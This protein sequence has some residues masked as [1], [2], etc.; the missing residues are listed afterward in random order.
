MENKTIK[1]KE[2][3]QSKFTQLLSNKK[4][5][6][7]LMAVM[8][9]PFLIAIGIFGTIVYREAK[10]LMNM[11]SGNT[12]TRDENLISQM[13]YVLRE[14]ATDL[15]K[16]YFAELKHAIEDEPKEGEEPV[17]DLTIAELI[18]KNY[19]A[20]FYTWTNKQGQYDVGGMYYVFDGRYENNDNFKENVYLA[21]RDGFYKYI[22]NYIT[23]YGADKL[24]EVENVE[25]TSSQKAPWKF[26]LNEHVSYKQDSEG[27][28]YD[29]RED[30]EYDAYLVSC[31]WTY[32]EE[33]S[34]N[35]NQF[36]KTINLLVIKNDG[37]FS[38]IEAS[39]S[40]INERVKAET[41]DAESD[42]E[43]EDSNQ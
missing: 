13:N 17:S 4:T 8:M 37:R 5:R 42:E 2:K 12:E 38:I 3:K 1:L 40:K 9:L 26:M 11:V 39:E 33:S 21:A 41:E 32:K 10:G 15:Q 31:K 22:S 24:I 19:V 25:I 36:P 29:Y 30:K 23:Q 35:L 18:A 34:L 16:E 43:I 28:W 27:E 7:I 20:D 6:Y 14:N